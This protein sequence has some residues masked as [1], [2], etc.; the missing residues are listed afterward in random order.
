MYTTSAIVLIKGGADINAADED[1]DTP[2]MTAVL[3][4]SEPGIRAL[5]QAGADM[6]P[7]K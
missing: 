1:G 6:K 7:N 3:A 2:L 5:I 4:R